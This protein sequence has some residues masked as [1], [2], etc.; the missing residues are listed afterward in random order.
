[1]KAIKV[2][3]DRVDTMK[4][5]RLIPEMNCEDGIA[6]VVVNHDEF[7]IAAEN[8]CAMAWAK[9]VIAREFEDFSEETI[10]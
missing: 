1:M 9:T 10:K 5:V 7:V 6:A 4:M 8:E 2:F 3:I